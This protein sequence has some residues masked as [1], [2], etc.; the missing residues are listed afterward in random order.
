MPMYRYIDYW[1]NDEAGK[2]AGLT[3]WGI[4]NDA[5]GKPLAG[6]TVQIMDEAGNTLMVVTTRPDGSYEAGGLPPGS[7][8]VNASFLGYESLFNGGVG[9]SSLATPIQS[10]NGGAEVNFNLNPQTLTHVDREQTPVSFELLGNYPNPFNPET[11]IS[12]SIPETTNLTL[13]IYNIRG[14]FVNE[15]VNG[16]MASGTHNVRW[17]GTNQ[18]GQQVGS[19]VYIYALETPEN[20]SSGKM[21][22]MR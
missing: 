13:R 10:G 14:E 22:L 8:L 9:S 11:T 1:M 21:I 6:A 15:L 2:N 16:R 5:A 17:L 12:F 7:Y 4:V 19:G 18:N 3:I 20:K